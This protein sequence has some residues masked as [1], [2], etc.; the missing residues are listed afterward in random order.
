MKRCGK[1]APRP[2]QRGRQGKPHREQDRIGVAGEIRKDWRRGVPAPSPGLVARGAL[3]GAS[4]RNGRPRPQGPDRTR[5]TGRLALRAASCQRPPGP[6]LHRPACPA[7]SFTGGRTRDGPGVAMPRRR[8]RPRLSATHV[9]EELILR[10]RALT[11]QTPNLLA[12]PRPGRRRNPPLA[13]AS[14]ARP[15]RVG[16]VLPTDHPMWTPA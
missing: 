6:D 2:R 11:K 16:T 7:R 9:H 14:C 5:L 12:R 4:Q 15:S 3:Q 10:Q 1:S 8:Q 13:R